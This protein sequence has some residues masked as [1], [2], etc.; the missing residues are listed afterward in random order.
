MSLAQLKRLYKKRDILVSKLEDAENFV[1][2]FEPDGKSIKQIKIRIGCM[3][4]LRDDFED[5]CSEIMA[6]ESASDEINEES[7]LTDIDSVMSFNDRWVDALSELHDLE[8]KHNRVTASSPI[9]SISS[10]NNQI[11]VRLPIINLPEF[12]G[13]YKEWLPFYDAF[14]NLI[15]QNKSLDDCQKFHYLKS[16]LKGEASR[17][18]ESLTISETNYLSAWCL[19]Q[20]RYRNTRLIVQSH[21]Q[22]IMHTP[23]ITKASSESL[24]KLINDVTSNIEALRVLEIDVDACDV[25]V[26][27]VVVSKLDNYTRREFENTL[28]AELPS[29]AELIAFLEKKCITMESMS[30]DQKPKTPINPIAKSR[31]PIVHRT[32]H[33]ATSKFACNYCQKKHSIIKCNEFLALSVNERQK[34]SKKRNLCAKCLRDN[35]PTAE[36]KSNSSCRVCNKPDHHTFLHQDAVAEPENSSSG[37]SSSQQFGINN[38]CSQTREPN[39]ILST[40]VVLVEDSDGNYHKCRCLLDM[41]SQLNLISK[42]VCQTLKLK[43]SKTNMSVHGVN[44]ICS[45]ISEITDVHIRSAYNQYSEKIRCYVTD[46]V[47]VNIPIN[48]F[49]ISNLKLPNVCLADPEFN[50]CGP[51][52]L[53]LNAEIFWSIL[54][55]GRIKLSNPHLY[56]SQTLLGWVVGGALSNPTENNLGISCHAAVR[57]NNLTLNNIMQK[58]W[59]EQDL[60]ETGPKWTAEEIKCENHFLNTCRRDPADGRFVVSLPFKSD[61]ANLGDSSQIALKR[62]ISLENKFRKE[63]QFKEKY[64]EA[65]NE[66]LKLGIIEEI[67]ENEIIRDPV[68]YLPHSGVAKKSS[69]SNDK[70]R[71]VFD[72]SAKSS[73]GQSLNDNL[74]TGPNLQNDLFNIL[75]GFRMH[76]IVISCDMEKMFLQVKVR[77]TDK[78]YQRLFW[79]PSEAVP[80]KHYRITRLVFGLTNSPYTAMRCVRQIAEESKSVF[81][82]VSQVLLHD[83]FM[84]DILCGADTVEEAIELRKQ[85]VLVLRESCF[86]LSKWVSNDIRVLCDPVHSERKAVMLDFENTNDAKVLGLWWNPKTDTLHYRVQKPIIPERLTKRVMLSNIARLYDPIGII[87]PLVIKAKIL[88]QS[89]WSLKLGWDDVVPAEIRTAWETYVHELDCLNLLKI[90]RKVLPSPDSENE[91]IAFSDASL[92][93]YGAIVYLKSTDKTGQVN[94]NLICSKTRVCPIKVETLPRLELCAALLAARMVHKLSNALRIKISNKYYFT[95]SMIVLHYIKSEANLYQVFVANRISQIQQLSDKSQWY[96]V[97][98]K[99]NP[100]DLVSRGAYANQFID[101]HFYWNGP[102]FLSQDLSSY[103]LQHMTPTI[104]EGTVPERRKVVLVSPTIEEMPV[105]T[106]IS[107]F[108]KLKR[109]IAYVWR[110]VNNARS[111]RVDRLQGPLQIIELNQS[112]DTIIKTVQAQTFSREIGALIKQQVIGKQSKLYNLDPFVDSKGILR[113]GGRLRNAFLPYE[114]KHPA[115][116]PAKHHIT[117]LLIELE[118]ISLLHAGPSQTLASLRTKFWPLKAKGEV[119][120]VIHSCMRCFR[121]APRLL[122]QKMGNLPSDRLEPCRPFLKVGIDYLGPLY[123]KQGNKRSKTKVKVW[124]ALFVCMVSK[125]VHL[126]VVGDLTTEC[127]INVLKRMTARRG[128]ISDIYCDNATTFVGAKNE[129]RNIA[130]LIQNQINNSDIQLYS[131]KENISWHFNPPKAPNFGGLWERL[132]KS[133]KFHFKRIVGGALLTHEEAFTIITQIE[134]II[135]SRPLTPLSNDPMDYNVLTPAHFLIGESFTDV[136]APDIRHV[137]SNRLDR[138]QRIEQLKQH[139]WNRFSKEVMSQLQER[140]KWRQMGKTKLH[141]GTLVLIQE[142]SPPMFWKLGRIDELFPG[143][144]GLPR[145]ATVRTSQGSFKRSVR[146]LAPLP[147]AGED[148]TGSDSEVRV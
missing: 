20:K 11:N 30:Q 121:V 22:S 23:E 82:K 70:V 34:Q 136:P 88:M 98:S 133:V 83:I 67:P 113:V 108:T 60:P 101:L 137:R 29:R 31:F 57:D 58:F 17:S 96:H 68:F 39:V 93:A 135:N 14:N 111:K 24:R 124:V 89:L 117:K 13:A 78:D 1:K 73:N 128:K 51:V 41:G 45:N 148:D 15:H 35:H 63:P 131:S 114:T 53:I 94:L 54:C 130:K 2:H 147:I 100:A 12:S 72:G 71:I 110:F 33:I 95:D 38:H 40:A 127:F 81:P 141:P 62:F 47:T 84:D 142:S 106:K 50:N 43:T 5:V 86:T 126:E 87:A 76:Q 115:V 56:L 61:K 27:S 46:K 21:V 37:N 129:L 112:Q 75:V 3:S 52:D 28:T 107:S 138:W 125:A 77:D 16:C 122:S 116:L 32:A 143:S 145:V 79:R 10:E 19:L 118:H 134:G 18:V 26:N 4:K 103:A 109:I 64:V 7:N 105:L 8:E 146:H 44:E 90:P 120:R 92:R 69:K 74:L 66:N 99:Q 139:F 6:I 91:L 85:L 140:S 102:L 144:D 36:C 59:T 9:T 48:S 119:R 25:F 132:V 49:D 42:E 65:F 55:P 123:I 80:L 104:S 97:E